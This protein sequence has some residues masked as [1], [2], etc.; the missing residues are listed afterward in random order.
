MQENVVGQG[1][2][3]QEPA[4]G[5]RVELEALTAKVRA[6]LPE[7]YQHC[8][9]AVSSTSMGSAPLIMDADGKVAWNAIWTSFCHLALAGGPPHRGKLLEPVPEDAAARDPGK[10]QQVVDEISRG[11]WLTTD[12]RT[13][14]QSTPGWVAAQCFSE[15]MAGWLTRAVMA[16][17]VFVRQDGH[18]VLL[19][20]GPDFRLQKEIKNVVTVLAKTCHYWNSHAPVRERSLAAELFTNGT[21]ANDLF[22]PATPAEALEDFAKYSSVVD[23]LGQ[24]LHAGTG[25]EIQKDCPHGWIGLFCTHETMAIWLMRAAISENVLARREGTVLFLPVC[26]SL[27][28]GNKLQKM[29]DILA[30]LRRLW[31][32]HAEAKL[33]DV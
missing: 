5:S 31:D 22:K 32:V 30:R 21:Q 19:P 24:A 26:P 23:R 20:A 10:Y 3:G 28:E 27:G 8:F 4:E 9:D 29:A 2:G 15:A 6:M 7:Q 25:L 1:H 18:A 13:L 33:Q 17:N 16:E 12:M 11:I 14:P